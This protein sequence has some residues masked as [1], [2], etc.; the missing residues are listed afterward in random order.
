MRVGTL[1]RE[2]N[3]HDVTLANSHVLVFSGYRSPK[4][5]PQQCMLSVF[6][7]TN[8]TLNF[9]THFLPAVYFWYETYKLWGELQ[10]S[11]EPYMLPMLAFMLCLC[12]FPLTSAVAHVFNCV[13]DQARHVCFFLDY[14]A[15]S[16]F[17]L[18]TAIANHAYVFPD[19]LL[20]SSF[21]SI[22]LPVAF[23]NAFASLIISCETRFMENGPRKKLFRFLAYAVP[24]NFDCIP[25]YIRFFTSP[26][27]EL[28]AGTLFLHLRQ[29][30][31]ALM[32]AFL[33][34]TH[35]P[36]RLYPGSFDII[37]H[38]HQLFHICTFLGSNDQ[39]RA[40]TFDLTHRHQQLEASSH[41]PSAQASLMLMIVVITITTAIL[42]YFTKKLYMFKRQGKPM[43]RCGSFLDAM[44]LKLVANGGSAKGPNDM[45]RNKNIGGDGK[46]EKQH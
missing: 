21:A 1:M 16:L 4:S 31:F 43:S 18:G 2:Y 20:N 28:L 44:Q 17:S 39:M 5:S 40:L 11:G 41:I 14:A 7:A 25:I 32:A 35:L 45:V 38:S 26:L 46:F 22:Y 3:I 13:S 9:W 10:L 29:F 37:G 6:S 8:E 30:M 19:G 23:F 33:Y 24:Y 15:L 12:T 36:E 42:I 34:T 27:S